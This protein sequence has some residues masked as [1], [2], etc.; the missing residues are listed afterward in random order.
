MKFVHFN[1]HWCSMHCKPHQFERLKFRLKCR[2]HQRKLEDVDK[3]FR[4]GNIVTGTNSF[5]NG[6]S[7]RNLM[8]NRLLSHF[9]KNKLFT[10]ISRRNIVRF[11]FI[12]STFEHS[13]FLFAL[14]IFSLYHSFP[15]PLFLSLN[16]IFL[17]PK[18]NEHILQVKSLAET[19][20][21]LFP[22]RMYVWKCCR[23]I[24]GFR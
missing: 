7:A 12:K 10:Q 11:D 16:L 2:E 8:N 24:H 15:F 21:F 9:A 18:N 23:W 20:F 4:S 1:S 14:I 19:V 3:W 13:S 5:A 6:T 17:Q 22:T